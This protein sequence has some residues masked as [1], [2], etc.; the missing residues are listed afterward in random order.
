MM[1]GRGGDYGHDHVEASSLPN[2]NHYDDG[3]DR[4]GE[5]GNGDNKASLQDVPSYLLPD[6]VKDFVVYFRRQIATQVGATAKR[7]PC[8]RPLPFPRKLPPTLP[9]ARVLFA[10]CPGPARTF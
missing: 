2:F 6:E 10:A 4:F 3:F 7:P 1:R 5:G 8:R 9:P